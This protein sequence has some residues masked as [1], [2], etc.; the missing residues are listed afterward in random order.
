MGPRIEGRAVAVGRKRER[1]GMLS[2]KEEKKE[3]PKSC[4]L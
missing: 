1:V 2:E 3:R 4:I